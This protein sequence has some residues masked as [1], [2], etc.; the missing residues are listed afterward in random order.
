MS[1]DEGLELEL[2][3]AI[4]KDLK[5]IAADSYETFSATFALL[6][7]LKYGSSVEEEKQALRLLRKIA[8]QVR[9]RQG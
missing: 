7:A 1:Q 4:S 6:D 5:A 9:L 3:K 2:R 8:A